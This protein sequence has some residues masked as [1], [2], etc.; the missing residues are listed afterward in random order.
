MQ[1]RIVL[2]SNVCLVSSWAPLEM[3]LDS[4]RPDLLAKVLCVLRGLQ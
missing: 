2:E 4:T 3:D 1:K